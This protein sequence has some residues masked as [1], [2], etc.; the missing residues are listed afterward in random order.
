MKTREIV[1]KIPA[2]LRKLL[3]NGE[4]ELLDYKQEVS[5]ERKIAKTI[6]SFANHKGGKLLIGVNDEEKYML[7]K[8]SGFCCKPEIALKI[9]EWQVGKKSI[10]EVDIPKGDDKPYFALGEDD[11]WWAYIRVND[12]SLLASKVVLDVLKREN[13]DDTAAVEF[14]SKEQALL[15]YL[16]EHKKIT[17]KQYCK[18]I[19]ISRKRAIRILVNLISLGIIR[20]HNTEK[21]EFYTL[22]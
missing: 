11:K 3:E 21:T 17:V 16:S 6:V 1:P 4:S 8:A 20:A 13:A 10:L 14:T 18:L 15:N 19:N 22:S 12:Q 7:E 2:P 9:K 5:N